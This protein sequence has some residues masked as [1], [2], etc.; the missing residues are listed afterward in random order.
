MLRPFLSTQFKLWPTHP[1]F[2][3]MSGMRIVVVGSSLVFYRVALTVGAHA[4]AANAAISE[5]AFICAFNASSVAALVTVIV[6][7]SPGSRLK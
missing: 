7:V 6:C 3:E 2:F 5:I 1:T 4:P